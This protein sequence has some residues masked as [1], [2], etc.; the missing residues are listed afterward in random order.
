MDMVWSPENPDAWF[1][2][3]RMY[4]AAYKSSLSWPNDRYLQNIAYLKLRNLTIHYD[5]PDKLV[6][7]IKI[8][9]CKV[10]VSGENLFTWTKLD[11]DYIDP[12][13]LMTN[14]HAQHYPK[15]KTFSVGFDIT[16]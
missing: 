16:F 7:K 8:N 10:Y 12:E 13:E 15:G 11:T 14:I 4:Y 1:P 5:L 3:P 6:N 2:F 9:N